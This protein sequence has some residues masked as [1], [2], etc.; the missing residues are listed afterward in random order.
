MADGIWL[1]PSDYPHQEAPAGPFGSATPD[2][3]HR[4][5]PCRKRTLQLQGGG[6]PWL[7]PDCTRSQQVL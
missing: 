3:R 7:S 1:N 4:Q 6:T 5:A 2:A